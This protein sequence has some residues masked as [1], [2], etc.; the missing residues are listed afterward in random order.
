[1][2]FIAAIISFVI[3]FGLI[4][5]G[6][7]QRTVLAEADSVTASET[8][9]TKA[10]VTIVNS[11]TLKSLPGR[12][13]IQIS[14]SKKIFAAYGRTEDVLAWVGDTSY[15]RV[16]FDRNKSTLTSKLMAGKASEVPNPQGSDLWLDEFSETDSLDFTV[17]VPDD[18]SVII[19]SD[20]KSAAPSNLSIRWPLDN[21]T[22]WSGP[23][24]VGGI[25]LL[26]IGLALYLWG[27]A[28]LRRSRGPRRKTPKMPKVPR[29][30]SYR[31][32]KPK[33]VAPVG[34]RRSSRRR[35]V[36]I[37]PVL[38][39]GGLTL[40]GCS[41]D[42]WPDFVTGASSA[43]PTPT[44][45]T[46]AAA[47]DPTPPA[48]TVPQLK[49]IIA[50]ISAVAAKADAD[51][52]V[53]LAKT[54]FDGP[55]LDLRSANYAIRKVDDTQ[56]ALA[57]I[58]ASTATVILP[59][60]QK[61]G[62]WPRVVFTVVVN[63]TDKKVPPVG[64]MLEQ[65]TPRSDYKVQYA[66]ALEAGVVL[67][68]LA[69]KEVGA[70]RLDPDVKLLELEPSKIALAYGDILEK[71]PTS[72]SAKYFD[73]SDDKLIGLI[74]LEYRKS[75]QAAL[76]A[77]AKMEFANAVGPYDSISLG[78]NDS[79]AIV[80][81]YLNETVTVTPVEAGAAVN[82]EGQ[83]KSLS[84]VTGSTKGTVAVYGDQLLFYVPAST[85]KQKISLLGFATGLTSAKE[86][87]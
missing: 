17:N 1:M 56:A 30:R 62:K 75:L 36:T 26:I 21:R 77:T 68:K 73:T 32:R 78:S 12:Q 39:I 14:G 5:Y 6:I 63:P 23:L 81:V 33:A 57:A 37:V 28:H 71:G 20:G 55:A 80:A 72:E 8:F 60:Q 54:R 35:M 44:A 84:G 19:V 46:T 13:E 70:P 79:G 9:T 59:Q 58:P 48:V 10:P 4:A 25:V 85:S 65:K 87:P 27:L 7:A 24:I 83:V 49:V 67:P 16:G 47:A 3:A 22:P 29:Q 86:L 34:G 53:E 42:S 51:K 45:S 50:R 31:P 2:R 64:L 66:T 74:G 69:A 11:S 18:I 43:T 38:L 76:P 40:S 52:D 41:P 82:P 15:N 61:A